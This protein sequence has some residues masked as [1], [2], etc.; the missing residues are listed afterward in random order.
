MDIIENIV[1]SWLNSKSY[2]TIQNLK[3]GVKEIDILAIKLG[4]DLKAK[5]AIHV[6]VSCSSHPVGYMG[7]SSSAK[8]RTSKEI[9]VGVKEYI[10]KKFNHKRIKPVVEKLIGKNY[11]KWFICGVMRDETTIDYFKKNGIEVFRIWDIFKEIKENQ[12]KF[13]AG[14]RYYQLLFLDNKTAPK[15][16]TLPNFIP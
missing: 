5:E 14:A 15:S 4:D 1:N 3:L 7:G 6:E 13:K 8:K 10:E 9:E 11:K 16:Y 2:F 12:D